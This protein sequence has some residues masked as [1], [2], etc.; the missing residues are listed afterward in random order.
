MHS[1]NQRYAPEINLACVKDEVDLDESDTTRPALPISMNEDEQE[2][3]KVFSSG[4]VAHRT[5][6]EDSQCEKLIQPLPLQDSFTTTRTGYGKKARDILTK[7]RRTPEA[8]ISESACVHCA[9]N[10]TAINET[11]TQRSRYKSS[12]ANGENCPSEFSTAKTPHIYS[13]ADPLLYL[14]PYKVGQRPVGC[15]FHGG[16]YLPQRPFSQAFPSSY[17][18]YR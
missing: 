2:S 7:D 9:R 15:I 10:S 14:P 16:E 12:A 18:Q 6:G 4:V 1:L 5:N 13:N 3:C 17:L 8:P 11:L